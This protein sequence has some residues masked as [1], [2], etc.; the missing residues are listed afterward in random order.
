MITYSGI[1]TNNLKN[2]SVSFPE[3]KITCITGIS[4]SG[5]SSLA[6]DTIFSESQR[7]FLELMFPQLSTLGIKL[8]IP[9]LENVNKVLPAVSMQ[10][11][12]NNNNPRSTI[13]TVTDISRLIRTIFASILSSQGISCETSNFSSNS[14]MGACPYCKGMGITYQIDLDKILSKNLSVSNGGIRYWERKS[15]KDYF[16]K[17]LESVCNL[18]SIP[19]DV[20]LMNLHR[21]QIEFLLYGKIDKPFTVKY[22]NLRG[23]VR[24]KKVRFHGV[25]DEVVKYKESHSI[26]EISNGIYSDYFF[27]AECSLC[28]G[29]RINPEYLKWT[30]E[31]LNFGE[32]E[33]LTIEDLLLWVQKVLDRFAKL[34]G[35]TSTC[36]IIKNKVGSIIKCNLGYLSLS[37][38]IPTLSGGEYQRLRLSSIINSSISN[39]LFIF[40]EPSGGLHPKDV[41]NIINLIKY[42]RDLGNTVLIVEHNNMIIKESDYIIDVG[43]LAGIHG[44]QII[45]MGEYRGLEH[46]KDSITAKYLSGIPKKRIL[47]NDNE[48]IQDKIDFSHVSYRNIV[49]QSFYL[50]LNK[51][52]V[53]TGVSGS[54]KST[55]LNIVYSSVESNCKFEISHGGRKILN[56]RAYFKGIIRVDQS[57]ISKNS[58]SILATYIKVFDDIRRIFALCKDNKGKMHSAGYYSFNVEGGRCP[59]C[60]GNGALKVELDFLNDTYITCDIC[61][62]KRFNETTL[63]VY[64]NGKN[65]WDVMELTVSEA[66]EFFG[67][68]SEIVKKLQPL[69]DIGLGYIKLGQSANSLSGGE[70]QRVKLGFEL[71]KGKREHCLFLLDEPTSGLHL[72]DVEKLLLAMEKLVESGHTIV[73]AEHNIDFIRHADFIVE[74]GPQGGNKGG[75]IIA[76][77]NPKQI[78]Q[79]T[80]SV[81]SQY[82]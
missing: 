68:H 12:K 21:E 54:G 63:S 50:P 27:S 13:G 57:P 78:Y 20:P 1:K 81:V 34:I 59:Y 26:S 53:I 65:I 28:K 67:S 25:L 41:M 30:I 15:D 31:D 71:G 14:S 33:Q 40:D 43:P 74:M 75:N 3:N 38:S 55:L 45:Y 48:K 51:L 19:Y 60:K 79:S 8:S 9:E 49:D 5:K 24:I 76:F 56:K 80:N 35:I 66:L 82:I 18:K 58:R 61:N 4:G 6:F 32:V 39:M 42:I 69:F 77:G 46:N 22:R 37:R 11:I 52:S 44:G 70:A 64:Y 23:N 47:N 72:Y 36:D 7:V 2:I 73:V 29:Y 10:Q 62:G 16:R 17:I